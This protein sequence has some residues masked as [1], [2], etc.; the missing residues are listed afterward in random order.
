MIND[1]TDDHATAAVK[2]QLAANYNP[3]RIIDGQ[4][5][6]LPVPSNADQTDQ[7][8]GLD[9]MTI[10]HATAPA[11]HQANTSAMP[12]TLNGTPLPQNIPPQAAMPSININNNAYRP[13]KEEIALSLAKATGNFFAYPLRFAARSFEAISDMALSVL[14]MAAIAV[15]TPTLIYAGF[16][17]YDARQKGEPMVE[18]A[19]DMGKTGVQVIGGLVAGIWQGIFG[20]EDPATD[21]G[22]QSEATAK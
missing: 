6:S 22:D 1:N 17:M 12:Y 15:V 14:R 4:Y 9:A 10:S 19:T 7:Q 5:R 3:K 21:T 20:N 16:Q 2:P 8:N 11:L 18:I 13:W